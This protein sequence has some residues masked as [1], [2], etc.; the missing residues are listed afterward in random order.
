MYSSTSKEQTIQIDIEL[1]PRTQWNEKLNKT[2]HIATQQL[3]IGGQPIGIGQELDDTPDY[4]AITI[5]SSL[6]KN[7][8]NH[9]ISLKHIWNDANGTE[10]ITTDAVD[11]ENSKCLYPKLSADDWTCNKTHQVISFN[12]V[13]DGKYDCSNDKSDTSD[14]NKNFCKIEP[15]LGYLYAI[16]SYVVLGALSFNAVQF[17]L[18]KK[19][20]TSNTKVNG[21]VIPLTQKIF[22]ICKTEAEDVLGSSEELDGKINTIYPECDKDQERTMLVRI[23]RTLR[24]YKP[25]E[26]A[27]VKVVE[28]IIQLENIRHNGKVPEYIRCLRFSKEN[29][30]YIPAFLKDMIEYHDFFSTIA[31]WA[32]GLFTFQNDWI[33]LCIKVTIEITTSLVKIIFFYY[34]LIKDVVILESLF[35]IDKKILLDDEPGHKYES[36]GGIDFT[37]LAYYLVLIFVVSELAI[38]FLMHL[39]RKIF[40]T[41]FKLKDDMTFVRSIINIFPIHFTLLEKCKLKMRIAWLEYKL[42]QQLKEQSLM[43]ECTEETAKMIAKIAEELDELEKQDHSLNILECEIQMLETCLER[44][45]QLIVQISLFILMNHFSRIKLLF[46][47]SFYGIPLDYIMIVTI[48]LTVYSM[49]TSIKR[50]RDRKIYPN[51]S[52]FF[53]TILYLLAITALLIPKLLVISFSLLNM[54]YLHP[55]I[56]FLNTLIIVAVNRLYFNDN[57]DIIEAMATA[58]NASYYKS[59]IENKADENQSTVSLFQSRARRIISRSRKYLIIMIR[60]YGTF[61]MFYVMSYMLRRVVFPAT[62]IPNQENSEGILGKHFLEE[63]VLGKAVL[64]YYW[65]YAILIFASGSAVHFILMQIYY[66]KGHPWSIGIDKSC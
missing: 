10:S 61:L 4:L 63:I 51:T 65:M 2:L 33:N 1:L 25:F 52:G 41:C 21:E 59:P 64:S 35:F 32:A 47:D 3:H 7:M 55:L 49:M 45:P 24:L 58:L 43:A 9:E 39:R 23:L 14:E 5:K 11:K 31:R 57:M 22:D 29:E 8:K 60:H 53:G 20:L 28:G 48:C 17:Y 19:R 37:L 66:I 44:E 56:Y 15:S 50:F 62:I 27:V 30:S 40:L 54:V 36:V 13:C 34:D 18:N 6:V 42:V 26:T 12:Q 16:V 46:E 38:Y